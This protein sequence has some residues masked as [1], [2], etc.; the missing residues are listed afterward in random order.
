M[1]PRTV[2]QPLLLAAAAAAI[3]R[4]A[5]AQGAVGLTYS[6]YTGGNSCPTADACWNAGYTYIYD[7]TGN[8]VFVP[9]SSSTNCDVFVGFAGSGSTTI[10]GTLQLTA[11]FTNYV[12]ATY[13]A[14]QMQVVISSGCTVTFARGGAGGSDAGAVNYASYTGGSTCAPDACI[15]AGFNYLVDSSANVAF[16][17]RNGNEN[18]ACNGYVGTATSVSADGKSGGISFGYVL[19]GSTLQAITPVTA[20]FSGNTLTT[21]ASGCTYTFTEPTSAATSVAT[22]AKSVMVAGAVAAMAV[23]IV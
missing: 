8:A 10:T 17:P 1:A 22:A 11:D 20:T 7:L 13:T 16:L 6:S 5:R 19:D 4:P 23:A 14:T 2:I 18:L 21:S 12:T 9:K 15:T 3:F